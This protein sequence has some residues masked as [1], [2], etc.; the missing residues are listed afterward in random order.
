[1]QSEVL[2]L[3]IAWGGIDE[4]GHQIP[5]YKSLLNVSKINGW[6]FKILTSFDCTDLVLKPFTKKTLPLGPVPSAS[7]NLVRP[8]SF[9]EYNHAA[10][11]VN[12]KKFGTMLRKELNRY[13]KKHSTIVVF[14]QDFT[15]YWL[16]PLQYA[17]KKAIKSCNN[18][19]I[20]LGLICRQ[21]YRYKGSSWRPSIVGRTITKA[22]IKK[23]LIKN[24]HNTMKNNFLLFVDTIPLQAEINIMYGLKATVLPIPHTNLFENVI[25]EPKEVYPLKNRTIRCWW[26]GRPDLSKGLKIIQHWISNYNEDDYEI[27]LYLAMNAL[28]PKVSKNVRIIYLPE[29]LSDREYDEMFN[30]VDIILLPYDKVR[31]KVSSSGIFAEAI[32]HKR[33]VLTMK[34]TWPGSELTRFGISEWCFDLSTCDSLYVLLNRAFHVNYADPRVQSL[35]DEYAK[36]HNEEAYSKILASSLNLKQW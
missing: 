11:L 20:Y 14:C 13:L 4:A 25:T 19:N 3:A 18:K 5:Y 29:I 32:I 17:L 34:S 35:Y 12:M 21:N 26:P 36:F 30:R 6:E 15:W 7:L 16:Q 2:F 27:E 23:A 9:W 1:M 33:P 28:L 8:P 10:K 24:L 22:L 31:Y